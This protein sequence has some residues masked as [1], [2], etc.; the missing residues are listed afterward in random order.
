M[1]GGKEFF[2]WSLKIKT[3]IGKYSGPRDKRENVQNSMIHGDR[4]STIHGAPLIYEKEI[5]PVIRDLA[6]VRR[7]E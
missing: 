6:R 5:G 1:V 7:L 3:G 2:T 4:N